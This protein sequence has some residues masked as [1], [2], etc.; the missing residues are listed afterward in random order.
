MGNADSKRSKSNT[1]EAKKSEIQQERPIKFLDVY[2]LG[3]QIGS[4]AY[5]QVHRCTH[6]DTGINWA[7]KCVEHKKLSVE[8]LAALQDEISIMRELDHPNIIKLNDVF[9]QEKTILVLELVVGGELFDRIVKKTNY[10]EKEARDLVALL[11]RTIGYIHDKDIVHRDLKPENLLLTSEDDDANIKICDFGFARHI[12][13]VTEHEEACGT[14]G[15]VSP[16]ILR[17]L[18]YTGKT[19]IWSIG[20]ITFILLGGYPPF[21]DDDQDLLFKKIRKG[22][23]TFHDTYWAHISEDAKDIIR[24]MLVVNH[25][26]R[27]SAQELLQH[28]W[29]LA[30]DA[31]LE[32]RNITDTLTELKRFNAKRK[33]R[34]AIDT[35][36]AIN[37]FRKFSTLASLARDSEA[38]LSKQDGVPAQTTE[39]FFAETPNTTIAAESKEGGV[40]DQTTA[41]LSAEIP[42]EA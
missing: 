34:S 42:Q 37:R 13:Q 5:S 10:N 6:K 27:K 23:Y 25:K 38:S 18:K 30:G 21:Y 41:D 36:M 33:M 20:V 16:E 22:Q 31:D 39:E 3:N 9:A 14:P 7:A 32:Q 11:L 35:V 26:E 1:G 29:I 12:S 17:G 8:D 28:P 2:T 19:D 4:G 40:P 24:Q 15:Y